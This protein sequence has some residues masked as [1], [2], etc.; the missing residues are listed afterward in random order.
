M[1]I[2]L[3]NIC[4][5]LGFLVGIPYFLFQFFF[6]KRYRAGLAERLGFISKE[7]RAKV[8]L[9]KTIWFHAVSVGEASAIYS[10][11]KTFKE[12]Y[13]H[14]VVVF[15]TTT[16]TGQ[17]WITPKLYSEDIPLYFPLDLYWVIQRVLKQIKPLSFIAVETEIWPNFWWLAHRQ[18]IALALVNG[19]LS[20][21]SFKGYSKISFFLKPVL[22]KLS[23][24]SCQTPEDAARFLRLG[25]PQERVIVGGNLKFEI[26]TDHSE[27]HAKALQLKKQ[28]GMTSQVVLVGGSTHAG[29]EE[30]LIH[31]YEKLC[32]EFPFLRLILAPRHPERVS[33]IQQLIQHQNLVPILESEENQSSWIANDRSVLVIDGIGKLPQY[34]ALATLVFM[35]KSLTGHGGQNLLEPAALGKVILFGPY[36]ENFKAIALEFLEENAAL[37][38]KN[39][40]MLEE[41]LRKLLSSESLRKQSEMKA[42]ELV[43]RNKGALILNLKQIEKHLLWP[44]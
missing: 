26:P 15:S 4:L 42:Q 17:E 3:Y 38:V 8:R 20:D 12:K 9:G 34:Y 36:M 19:R 43:N 22:N 21:R 35:G 23:I 37:E 24:L 29:E 27:L 33:E 44:R 32:K 31:C 18:K 30:I 6:H 5:S 10:L 16:Q 11:Y 28:F 14:M 25:A 1:M 13:P 2:L 7:K 39:E 41:T 40:L